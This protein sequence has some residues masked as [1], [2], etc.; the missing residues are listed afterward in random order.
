MDELILPAPAFDVEYMGVMFSRTT[1]EDVQELAQ[2]M[3]P[4]DIA[5]ITALSGSTPK[6]ALT[7][8]VASSNW[9]CTARVGGG[10]AC[11]FGVAPTTIL[12]GIGSPWLL[13]STIMGDNKVKFVRMAPQFVRLMLQ[14]FQ[15]LENVV[16]ARNRKAVRWLR[17]AG[18]TLLEPQRMGPEGVLFHRFYMERD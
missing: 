1:P 18:F 16:D 12:T 3:R 9:S 17:V 11:I 8:S 4:A 2:T 10:L 7:Y 5:E 15:R 13:G 14:D 6:V